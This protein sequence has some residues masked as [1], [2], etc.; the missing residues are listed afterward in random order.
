MSNYCVNCK[1]FIRGS[2]L[3]KDRCASPK[4]IKICEVYGPQKRNDDIKIIRQYLCKGEWFEPL[5]N[6][7]E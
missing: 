4:N 5:H 3:L 2:H 7:K 1:C 6:I